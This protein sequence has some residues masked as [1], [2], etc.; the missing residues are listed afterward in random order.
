MK[1][2]L[3]PSP[4]RNASQRTLDFLFAPKTVAIIGATDRD[5]SVGRAV[6]ENL[7][8]FKGAV[9]PVNPGHP[10]LLGMPSFP[11]VAAVP[12]RIDL[13]VIVTPAE[14]VP[15][16]VRECA[17]AGARGAVI[18]SAGFKEIGAEAPRWSARSA[19]RLP[20]AECA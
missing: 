4:A 17:R 3:K 19:R 8:G 14:T 1:P 18:L 2:R 10:S 15:G 7:R 20:Q 16:I 11:S 13:A 5:G 12:A 6:L 9:Y